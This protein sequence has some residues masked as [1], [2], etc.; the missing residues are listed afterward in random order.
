MH[1]HKNHHDEAIPMG[2]NNIGS[3]EKNKHNYPLIITKY[4]ALSSA[5]LVCLPVTVC[6]C[7]AC[8]AELLSGQI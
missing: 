4:T 8:I 3:Y 1:S 5:L 6:Y 7:K 2:T